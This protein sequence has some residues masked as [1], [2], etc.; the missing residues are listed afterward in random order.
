MAMQIAAVAKTFFRPRKTIAFGTVIT[1]IVQPA[2]GKRTKVTRLRYTAAGTAHTLTFLRPLGSKQPV[3][4][5]SGTPKTANCYVTAAV[6]AAGTS[7]IL[8]RDPGNYSANATS[9][10]AAAPL[11]ANNL[12]A[13][14]DLLLIETAVP[15]NFYLATVS[16]TPSTN[17]D[18]GACTVTAT[19]APTGGVPANARVFFLGITTDTDPRTGEAHPAYSGTASTTTDPATDGSV[20]VESVADSEPMLF[21]SDNATA[22]GVL[23]IISGVYGDN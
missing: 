4:P 3:P 12:I 10:G 2:N 14:S 17:S 18:T 22:T 13:A 16:G 8:S 21:Y 15:G 7:F 11:A 20:V 9:D 6:A 19:A 23:E 1:S 5:T